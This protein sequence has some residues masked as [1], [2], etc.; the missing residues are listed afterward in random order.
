[1]LPVTTVVVTDPELLA[2]L[3]SSDNLIVFKGPNGEYVRLAGPAPHGQLPAGFKSPIS[4]E[5]F[6]E[7]RKRPSSG[8][9]L[10]EF[11]K[12]MERGEWKRTTD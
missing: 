6:E 9:S 8:I 1:M 7:A 12:L 5:E 11:W 3:A 2:K 10:S 4:D